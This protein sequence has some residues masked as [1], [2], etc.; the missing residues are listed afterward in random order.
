MSKRKFESTTGG[1]AELSSEIVDFLIIGAQKAGTMALLKNLNKH[2]DIYL[3][4]QECHFFDLYWHL[5]LNW[6]KSKFRTSK[7]IKGEKTPELIYVDACAPRIKEVCPKAKFILCL[8]DP[9]KRAYSSWNMEINRGLEELPFDECVDREL[10]TM[11]GEMRSYGTSQYH[12]IQRGFY[13]EQIIRF[14]KIFPDKNQ[15]LI[16]IAERM[17]QHPDEEYSKIFKFLG[18]RDIRLQVEEDHVGSYS[19]PMSTRQEAK[20]RKIFA[21]HNERLFK[22]LGYRVSEW[23]TD[24][25]KILSKDAAKP[26]STNSTVIIANNDIKSNCKSISVEVS[27]LVI[28]TSSANKLNNSAVMVSSNEKFTSDETRTC[29]TTGS[30]I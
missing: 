12:Y 6:Y 24:Q 2:P 20:L 21:P 30:D 15:L 26:Q 16:V 22:F 10:T 3:L 14:M 7:P 28:E 17:R 13:Y 23:E 1:N 5:G 9:V 8:R 4:P 25:P 18:A 27:N 11:M 19:K 29:G